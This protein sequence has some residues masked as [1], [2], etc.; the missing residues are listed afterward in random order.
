VKKYFLSIKERMMNR[1]T[2]GESMKEPS[3]FVPMIFCVLVLSVLAGQLYGETVFVDME[4]LP[5]CNIDATLTVT[6]VLDG[7]DSETTTV[8]G[9]I[10]AELDIFFDAGIPEVADV[11]SI[12]F[13]GGQLHFSDMSF[14]INFGFFGAM[15]TALT[16]VGGNLDSPYGAGIVVDGEFDCTNHVLILNQGMIDVWGTGIV[17]ETFEPM[18]FDLNEESMVLSLANT[19]V[20]S[21]ALESLEGNEATYSVTLNLPADF[22][23]VLFGDETVSVDLAGSGVVEAHGSFVRCPLRADL[24][25]EDC[26]VDEADLAVFIDQWLVSGDIDDCGLSAEMY[27]E[28]CYVGLGDFAVIAKEW[29]SN[30]ILNN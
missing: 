12:R 20:V 18:T 1:I 30:V 3:Y 29:L 16:G 14:A 13:T 11:N 6:G 22:D 8:T 4:V 15:Y 26:Q 5:G 28:D 2:T 7:S 21:A 17:G 23:E 27:G 25:G 24:A 19:G 10:T 9:N